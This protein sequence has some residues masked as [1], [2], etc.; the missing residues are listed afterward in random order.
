MKKP[1]TSQLKKVSTLLI[2]AMSKSTI[3][4]ISDKAKKIMNCAKLETPP[5]LWL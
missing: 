2:S 3:Y 1:D 4:T 5:V